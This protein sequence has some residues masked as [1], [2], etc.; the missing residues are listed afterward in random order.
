VKPGFG[1]LGR[2]GPINAPGFVDRIGQLTVVWP[3]FDGTLYL[4]VEFESKVAS[5][6]T[7]SEPWAIADASA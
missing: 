4:E 6:I 1:G 2:S 3:S 5:Q 7:S